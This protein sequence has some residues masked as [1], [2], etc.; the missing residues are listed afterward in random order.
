MLPDPVHILKV[1]F[2]LACASIIVFG[3]YA[4]SPFAIVAVVSAV[5]GFFVIGSNSGLMALTS[6]TYPTG[7][8]GTGLG[9]ATGIGRI[10][11]LVAPIA[12]GT[13]LAGN[14]SVDKICKT[15][16]LLALVV[17]GILFVMGARGLADQAGRPGGDA[18][19]HPDSP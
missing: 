18:K 6:L 12:G 5:M 14:W 10:G 17:V 1:G 13:M 19:D 9:W 15:N 8:R 3:H 2:A 11:S 7:I 16:A 4:A